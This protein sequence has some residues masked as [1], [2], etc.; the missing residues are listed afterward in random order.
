MANAMPGDEQACSDAWMNAFIAKPYSLAMSRTRTAPWLE[1]RAPSGAVEAAPQHRLPAPAVGTSIKRA[2]CKAAINPASI[3][4]LR[5]L[6][7][8]GRDG[9][10]T[11]LV[12]SFL[13]S[14]DGQLDDLVTAIA[15]GDAKALARIANQL[16]SSTYPGAEALAQ[17]H[18]ELEQRGSEGRIADP[19]RLLGKT[20]DEQCCALAEL[21]ELP[22]RTN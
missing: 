3:A 4:T 6:D 9:L 2:E 22:P 19:E 16:K 1:V 21:R 14:E 12:A 8:S 20:R 5:E 15:D 10:V 11:E 13:E 17:C 18:I 7:A